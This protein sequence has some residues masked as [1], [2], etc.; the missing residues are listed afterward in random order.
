MIFIKMKYIF[1]TLIG[2]LIL[3]SCTDNEKLAE[4]QQLLIIQKR[5]SVF[6]TINDQWINQVPY[7]NQT[8]QNYL[9]NW[10][11]WNAFEKEYRVKPVTS[12]SAFRNK[13]KAL[14]QLGSE[15]INNIPT[16]YDKPDVR[17]RIYLLNANLNSLEMLLDLDIIPGK[18][19]KELFIKINKNYQSIVNQFDE[20][21]IR[22]AIPMEVGEKDLYQKL[23]T[24]KRATL[25]AIPQEL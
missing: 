11:E 15:M 6:K 19:V 23:D 14:S 16:I 3:S 24:V 12:I 8:M 1:L 21:N 13:S 2:L 9:V 7:T 5:D 25:Q 17:S 22:K 4:E 10:K 18:E 20:I